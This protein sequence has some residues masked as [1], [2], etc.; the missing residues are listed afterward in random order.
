[1]CDASAEGLDVEQVLLHVVPRPPRRRPTS[2]RPQPLVRVREGDGGRQVQ[3]T[4]HAPARGPLEAA[5]SWRARP[6]LCL[7]AYSLVYVL[8]KKSWR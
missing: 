7:I 4:P 1:V 3:L 2:A 6:I 5:A 8:K